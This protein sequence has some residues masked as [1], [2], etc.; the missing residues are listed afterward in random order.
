[1]L[2]LRSYKQQNCTILLQ[3]FYD[4]VLQRVFPLMCQN[5]LSGNSKWTNNNAKSV[6]HVLK[7]AID[8]RPQQLPELIDILR[9]LAESQYT[10]ADRAM[11]G[12]GDFVL[13]SAFVKHQ[14]T[15]DSWRSKAVAACFKI[16]QSTSTVS[17]GTIT[18]PNTPGGGKK[19]HQRKR[20]RAEKTTSKAKKVLLG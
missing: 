11:C 15:I 9:K 18:V 7:Q 4:Y 6:N 17:D 14:H 3:F 1:M 16:A 13:H 20:K 19:L 2:A 12:V 10:E 8:W 5:V